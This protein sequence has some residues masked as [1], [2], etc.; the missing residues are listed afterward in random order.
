MIIHDHVM[1]LGTEQ[2]CAHKAANSYV[3]APREKGG[4]AKGASSERKKGPRSHCRKKLPET[5]IEI[6]HEIENLQIL[7]C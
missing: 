4:Q 3:M 6:E 7:S 5:N 1:K 2:A